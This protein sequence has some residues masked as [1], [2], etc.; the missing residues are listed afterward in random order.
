MPSIEDLIKNGYDENTQE[1]KP[2]HN[3]MSIAGL[4]IGVL[5]VLCCGLP[6]VNSVM[7]MVGLVISLIGKKKSDMVALST[8]AIVMNVVG[9]ISTLVGILGYFIYFLICLAYV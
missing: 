9:M 7:A 5:S 8:W 1:F 2:A 6:C 4:I 3:G